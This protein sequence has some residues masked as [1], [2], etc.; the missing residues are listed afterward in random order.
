MFGWKVFLIQAAKKKRNDYRK[1]SKS[2]GERN[3]PTKWESLFL[4]PKMCDYI[5]DL[6][7][8]A[9]SFNELSKVLPLHWLYVHFPMR[10]SKLKINALNLLLYSS[11]FIKKKRKKNSAKTCVQPDDKSIPTN[12]FKALR[13][14]TCVLV[15]TVFLMHFFLL[16]GN[17]MFYLFCFV[18]PFKA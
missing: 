4:Q 1:N 13:C 9:L 8:A 10:L 12:L 15:F 5:V 2:T 6:E 7:V 3:K 17:L 14:V 16:P 18:V 11:S